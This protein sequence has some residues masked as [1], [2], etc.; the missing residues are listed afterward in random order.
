MGRRSMPASPAEGEQS[1][2]RA[3][4]QE[5]GAE[6]HF[7]SEGAAMEHTSETVESE[8]AP[9]TVIVDETR[10][11]PLVGQSMQATPVNQLGK[12]AERAAVPPPRRFRVVGLDRPKLYI[13]RTNGLG[14]TSRMMPG[15]ILDERL[16]DIPFIESQG[17]NLVEV[18]DTA[19]MGE[20]RKAGPRAL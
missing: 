17:F 13:E 18:K 20:V 12:N 19:T 1:L 8:L 3:E 10:S 2:P 7:T 4:E 16:Y 15:K 14:K 6:L 9:P 5:R 11:A